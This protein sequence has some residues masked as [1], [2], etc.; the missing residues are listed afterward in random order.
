[1]SA[2]GVASG[3]TRVAPSKKTYGG[4]GLGQ[5]RF[6]HATNER[7]RTAIIARSAVSRSGTESR[8]PNWNGPR[9]SAPFAAQAIGQVLVGGANDAPSAI[10]AYERDHVGGMSGRLLDSQ[11]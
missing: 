4:N 11:A 5:D 6:T 1:M 7:L 3:T 9:L 2:T 10:A 8:A